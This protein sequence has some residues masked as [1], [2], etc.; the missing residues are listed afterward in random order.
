MLQQQLDQ[1][2]N[3]QHCQFDQFLGC[4]PARRRTLWHGLLHAAAAQRPG[5]LLISVIDSLANRPFMAPAGSMHE[6]EH[7]HGCVSQAKLIM[8]ACTCHFH[9]CHYV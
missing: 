3:M 7:E 5:R 2:V 1:V 6:H 9:V 4:L 8:D